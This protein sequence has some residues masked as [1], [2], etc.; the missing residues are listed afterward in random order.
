MMDLVTMANRAR[1]AAYALMTT[2]AQMRNSVLLAM[3]QALEEQSGL[4]LQ[5][6]GRDLQKARED[7]AGR[8]AQNRLT[9]SPRQIADMARKMRQAA[10]L[11]DPIGGADEM[12]RRPNGLLVAKRR[13]P[14]GVVGVLYEERPTVTADAIGLCLKSGNAVILKGG[15]EALQTNRAIVRIGEEAA[16]R[17]GLPGGCIGLVEDFSR[18]AAAQMMG[19]NGLIDVLI[20]QGGPELIREAE[21]NAT[22]PLIRMGR[23]NCHI[24]VDD[25]ADLEMAARI[26]IN[27]KCSR[28]SA[29]GAAETLLISRSVARGFLEMAAQPLKARGVELRGCPEVCALLPYA[30]RARERDWLQE[31]GDLTL[32][33]KVVEGIEEAVS[34]I[35]MYGSGH[36][37]CI[38]TEN[39][40]KALHF[41]DSID[42]AAVYVNA[43]TCFTEGEELGVGP[44]MGISTQK[45][46]ARGP[47]G[48]KQL[49]T[50]KYCIFGGGQI[51]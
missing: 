35:N 10:V 28:P 22:V 11:P 34:H 26:V 24:Y 30:R 23:G 33:V 39:Y 3:A 41:M 6:N 19:S 4:L 15:R 40:S 14:L 8:D 27:A 17:A 7:G 16:C 25:E 13:V 32:S 50:V 36:S 12:I 37:E 21:E 5:A 2:N 20:L 18:E 31:Y 46:H 51:R 38:V 45:L 29:G 43:S 42:A 1:A 47:V 49:T 48:L 9:L 44:E